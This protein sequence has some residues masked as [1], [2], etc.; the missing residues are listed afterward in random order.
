MTGPKK[1]G[2]STVLPDFMNEAQWN[3]S[4]QTTIWQILAAYVEEDGRRLPLGQQA[5]QVS[6]HSAIVRRLVEEW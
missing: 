4:S 5:P 1:A 3:V 2:R 6:S